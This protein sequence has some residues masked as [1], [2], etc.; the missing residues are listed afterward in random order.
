HAAER[1]GERHAF[2][3]QRRQIEM[4]REARLRLLGGNDFEK[5]FLTRRRAHRVEQ[6]IAGRVNRTWPLAHGSGYI[7]TV[8]PGGKPSRSGATSTQ[9][10]ACANA[11]SGK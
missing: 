4:A 3:R 2:A 1:V 10:A 11:W 8:A 6:R 7:S 5:L 9:P